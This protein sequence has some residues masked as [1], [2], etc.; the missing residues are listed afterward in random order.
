MSR[1][2]NVTFLALCRR[3]PLSKPMPSECDEEENRRG[4]G[5]KPNYDSPDKR[6]LFFFRVIAMKMPLHLNLQAGWRHWRDIVGQSNDES[7]CVRLQGI[8]SRLLAVQPPE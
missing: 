4:E 2:F 3:R 5:S 1:I 6:S 7:R 8:S